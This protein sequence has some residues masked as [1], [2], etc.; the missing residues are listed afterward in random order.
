M[1]E[2]CNSELIIILAVLLVLV[3]YMFYN[4]KENFEPVIK[5]INLNLT[6]D[7]PQLKQQEC[8]V[9]KTDNEVDDYLREELLKKSHVCP[10]A[11]Y[12]DEALKKYKNQFYSFRNNVWQTS[13]E[14]DMVDKLN[15]LYLAE[16]ED[17][18]RIKEGT[19][20]KDLFDSLVKSEVDL[21]SQP[22]IEDNA[23]EL[24]GVIGNYVRQAG[25][26]K[27]F[28]RDNWVYGVETVNNGGLF[29]K[30]IVA[31]DPLEEFNY[32]F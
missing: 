15:E 13:A 12:S 9:Q 16:N 17:D 20:I 5:D 23:E 25:H 31:S 14:D 24:G 32:A 11:E 30:N 2:N 27:S 18:A 6:L 8:T 22:K 26:D 19:K 1:F 3:F 28:V 10:S 4:K 21:S 29:F 7:I